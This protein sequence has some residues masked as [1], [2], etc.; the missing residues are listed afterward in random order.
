DD[1]HQL[2]ERH[3]AGELRSRGFRADAEVDAGLYRLHAV[4]E[5]LANLGMTHQ[6][7]VE[8]LELGEPDLRRGAAFTRDLAPDQVH[9]LDAG[10]A[11]VDGGD[12]RVAQVLRRAGLLDEAHAA[13]HLHAERGD[14]DDGLGAAP[15]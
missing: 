14:R 11:L 4:G 1:S 8:L 5:T 15:P 3:R 12:A 7:G 10:G 13:V 2:Q 9:R 6:P